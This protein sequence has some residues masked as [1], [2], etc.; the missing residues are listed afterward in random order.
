M[1][2]TAPVSTACSGFPVTV[3][4]AVTNISQQYAASISRA[5]D[6]DSSSVKTFVANY[7]TLFITQKTIKYS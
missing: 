6:G 3:Q 4:L 2:E 7:Q 5:V 1:R